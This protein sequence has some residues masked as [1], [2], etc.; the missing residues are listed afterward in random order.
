VGED[1]G[2]GAD[3]GPGGFEAWQQFAALYRA[4]AEAE[5]RM[6]YPLAQEHLDAAA[7]QAM[8]HEMAVRR[9]VR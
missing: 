9:G 6:A 4:H 5:D 2:V 7:R 3:A 1:L 8:G